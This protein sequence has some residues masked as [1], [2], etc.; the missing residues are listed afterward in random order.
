LR[1]GL[2]T[3]LITNNLDTIA[4]MS[5]NPAIGG[6]VDSILWYKRICSMGW[7][8]FPTE[9]KIMYNVWCYEKWNKNR[10]EQP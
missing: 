10:K 8:A 3:A 1:L 2:R 4:Q 5:C 9:W 6:I 7:T